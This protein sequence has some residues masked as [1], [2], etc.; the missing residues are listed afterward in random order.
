[1]LVVRQPIWH[2][3]LNLMPV[4]IYLTA[5]IPTNLTSAMNNLELEFWKLFRR[6]SCKIPETSTGVTY[7]IGRI[8]LKNFNYLFWLVSNFD[9]LCDWLITC[10]W[11]VIGQIIL[12]NL[13]LHFDWSV[14]FIWSVIGQFDWWSIDCLDWWPFGGVVNQLH[15]TLLHNCFCTIAFAAT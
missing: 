12:K 6:H 7:V 1:M 11:S 10:N 3:N 4:A 9:L 2:S 8:T 5:S 13:K 15:C 14:I